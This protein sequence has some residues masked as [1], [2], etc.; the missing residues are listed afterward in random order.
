METYTFINEDIRDLMRKCGIKITIREEPTA[1]YDKCRL[2][3]Y[4]DKDAYHNRG[5][6]ILS[7]HAW[8]AL[9]YGSTKSAGFNEFD[10]FLMTDLDHF[11]DYIYQQEGKK[12]MM[13]EPKFIR[14]WPDLLG[15]ENEK[16]YINV[17]LSTHTFYGNQ[18]EASTE[19]LRKCGFNVTL[20]NWDA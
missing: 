11:L 18:Y 17:D 14:D 15:M 8:C 13:D 19:I 9:K 4:L 6:T 7:S 2:V 5:E 20:N 1:Q 12:R 3:I 10:I 16:Y